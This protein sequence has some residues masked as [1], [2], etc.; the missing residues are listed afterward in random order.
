MLVLTLYYFVCTHRIVESEDAE[1]GGHHHNTV[2]RAEIPHPKP[3]RLDRL[4]SMSVRGKIARVR[5]RE[6]G[7]GG[8]GADLR[9]GGW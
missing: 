8:S 2:V 6:R 9:G 4:R 7:T 3:R 1:E 5:T